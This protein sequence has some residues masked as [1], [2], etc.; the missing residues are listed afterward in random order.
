MKIDA[1]ACYTESHEWVRKEGDLFV[2]GI[3]DHAQESM[4]DIVF[5]ELPEVGN[6]FKK[7]ASIGTVESVK[8]ASDLMAPMSG[9]VTEVNEELLNS[10]DMANSDPYGAG[11]MMKFKAANPAEWEALLSP[12]AYGELEEV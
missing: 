10:P 8:A 1:N 6:T 4:S 7:G 11:W 2:Y 5:V 9:E 3:T 12:E